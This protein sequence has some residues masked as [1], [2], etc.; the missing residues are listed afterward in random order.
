MDRSFFSG[1]LLLVGIT[2]LAAGL[3]LQAILLETVVWTVVLAGVGALLSAWG[4]LALRP[5]LSALLQRRRTEVALYTLGVIGVLIAL[6]YLSVRY[7]FRF[8]LSAAGLHSLSGQTVTM[9]KRLEKPVH[10][11]FFTIH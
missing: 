6:A 8:D 4:V 3:A 7:P 1:L 5:E 2:L 10:I 11:V 9:L